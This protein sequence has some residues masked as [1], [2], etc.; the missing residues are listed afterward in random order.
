MHF[1][2]LKSTLITERSPCSNPPP[3]APRYIWGNRGTE[4]LSDAP[5][6]H[7]APGMHI[8]EAWM[9]EPGSK[10]SPCQSRA[11]PFLEGLGRFFA[12]NSHL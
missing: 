3:T 4:G 2:S 11:G 9:K 6:V 12:V 7:S 1:T 10:V 5:C 8:G